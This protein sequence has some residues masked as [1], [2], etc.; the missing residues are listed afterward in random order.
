M[1][2]TPRSI[3]APP[4]LRKFYDLKE[5]ETISLENFWKMVELQ[6]NCRILPLQV[7]KVFFELIISKVCSFKSLN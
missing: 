2:P 6:K 5:N 3:I 7:S 4:A 1:R